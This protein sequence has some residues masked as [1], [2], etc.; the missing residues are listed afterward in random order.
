MLINFGSSQC[1][2]DLAATIPTPMSQFRGHPAPNAALLLYL[3]AAQL[4]LFP[5]SPPICLPA[6]G[7]S[8]LCSFCQS[9]SFPSL[10]GIV[11]PI[12]S[13]ITAF[14]PRCSEDFPPLSPS[15]FPG[16]F[17]PPLHF[18]SSPRRGL[19]DGGSGDKHPRAPSVPSSRIQNAAREMPPVSPA[20]QA[21]ASRRGL[22]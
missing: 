4:L 8:I 20:P 21:R 2:M 5:T 18:L 22:G 12:V 1:G 19:Q 14:F 7:P 6:T 15:P 10:F 17:S 13:S 16:F 9:A 11:V 3:R